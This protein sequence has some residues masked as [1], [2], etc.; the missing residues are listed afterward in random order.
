MT[1]NFLVHSNEM[2]CRKRGRLGLDPV[3]VTYMGWEWQDFI[4]TICFNFLRHIHHIRNDGYKWMQVDIIYNLILN[5]HLWYIHH[6]INDDIFVTQYKIVT[7]RLYFINTVSVW[8]NPHDSM[9]YIMVKEWTC[10]NW[11]V[12]LIIFPFQ[13][14]PTIKKNRFYNFD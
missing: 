4:I 13:N 1:Y 7:K 11:M 9:H 3:I 6:I 2:K 12:L 8:I 10:R 5:V 14:L